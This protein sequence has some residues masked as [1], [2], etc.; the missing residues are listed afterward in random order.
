MLVERDVIR[1]TAAAQGFMSAAGYKVSPDG[2]WSTLTQRA[3]D[4][5]SGVEA[6]KV[7]ALM[8]AVAGSPVSANEIVAFRSAQRAAGTAMLE[9]GAGSS[10]IKTLITAV[11]QS[12]GV[13]PQAALQFARVES[14]FNPNARSSTGATGLF[15]LTGPAI[16]QIGIPAPNGNTFD[17]RWNATV[18]IKYMKWVARYLKTDFTNLGEIY[19]GYNMGVGNVAKLKAHQYDDPEMLKMLKVQSADLK[20]GGAKAYLANAKA[21]V[22]KYA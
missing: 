16:K 3:Y 11:A 22:G 14:N 17:P 8:S 5:L 13:P 10:D 19:A 4:R 18:G 12:E 7:D 6:S 9:S 20:K 21:W 15:Q 2:I 1:A